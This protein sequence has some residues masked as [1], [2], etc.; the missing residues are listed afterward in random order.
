MMTATEK[1]V[2]RQMSFGSKEVF[3]ELKEAKN[4]ERSS[5][6]T[7]F[8]QYL[9]EQDMETMWKTSTKNGLDAKTA[10]D[11]LLKFGPNELEKVPPPTFLALFLRQLMS[12]VILLLIGAAVASV[13]VNVTDEKRRDDVLSYT[14]GKMIF[15]LVLVNAA[16]AAYV[17]A[18]AGNGLDALAKLGAAKVNV[19]RDGCKDTVPAA[20]LVK[21]DVVLLETGD[22]VPADCR[23]IADDDFKVSEMPLTGEPDDRMKVSKIPLQGSTDHD[24]VQD[25]M[26]YSGCSVTSGKGTAV[27]VHTGMDTKI[28]KI[29]GRLNDSGSDDN[30]DDTLKEGGKK[31]CSCLTDATSNQTPLQKNVEKLGAN[32]AVLALLTCGSVYILGGLLG[33]QD[34]ES[35]DTNPWLYMIVIAVTLAVAAI[36]EGIPLCV[37]ISLS[38]GCSKMLSKNVLIKKIAAVETLGSA[39][40]I[41]SD[42][43][44]T[45]TEAKM[46]MQELWSGGAK[47]AVSGKGFEPVGTFTDMA[48]GAHA[49]DDPS[50]QA[51]LKTAL[52][53]CDTTLEQEVGSGTWK[54]NG[55]SSEGPIVVASRKVGLVETEVREKNPLL[56]QVPFS[57]SRKMMLTVTNMSDQK[58][59]CTG[60]YGLRGKYLSVVKGAPGFL[61]SECS[62]IVER[63]GSIVDLTDARRSELEE[64]NSHWAKQAL[65]VLACAAN[66]TQSPPCDFKS[67]EISIDEKF[68]RCRSDLT[69]VGMWAAL[70]PERD[71]VPESVLSARGAGIRVIMITGDALETATA[72]AKN[73]NIIK[74]EDGSDEECARDCRALRPTG[75]KPEDYLPEEQIDKMTASVRVFARAQPEDKLVIVKSLQRQ[76]LVVAMT[77]DGVND[78]PALDRAEIGVAMGLQGTEV[79]KGAADMV[80]VDDNFCRIID[81]VELGRAIYDGIQ[82]FVAFIMSV[83]IAEVIQIFVCIICGIPIMRT[84]LQ[85]LFLIIVTDLPPSIALGMEPGEK[86]NMKKAPR[87]REEPIVLV[88]MWVS[89]V[90]NG[91]ILSAVIIAIYLVALLHYCDGVVFLEDILLI[92]DNRE[93]KLMAARTVAFVSLVLSENVRAYTSRSFSRFFYK[94]IFG[95]TCM[96]YAVVAAQLC[97]LIAVFTPFFSDEILGLSGPAI[98]TWGWIVAC[99]G[100]FATAVLCELGKVLTS[101]QMNRYNRRQH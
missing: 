24:F 89:I 47:F 69:F 26:I 73:V 82:K 68:S 50:V 80:L 60:G 62:K 95:N 20:D 81:A 34:P 45:L 48:T 1:E 36:P 7:D 53:C 67:G 27:V 92:E 22:V 28:G 41:C 51:T 58:Q 44:G 75:L 56:F 2:G 71:G 17:E 93:E 23:V 97:L 9:T 15:A 88:W 76:R 19:L 86:L 16:I 100:P 72:I 99:A 74:P 30:S 61:I 57:S 52:L 21:G 39:S 79:A 54:I 38:I 31:F 98:W 32:I 101:W 94:N 96:Q 8:P 13:L 43:T 33:T 29:A 90:L 11:Y 40:V 55:N 83:H 46:T 18:K 78:A 63:D 64:V 14:T 85:I 37:T 49:N 35:T 87:P 3:D 4:S 66:T 84:P 59:I 77:G 5:A 91:M 12:F 42:K 6:A 25:N 70:D 65:R 10:R